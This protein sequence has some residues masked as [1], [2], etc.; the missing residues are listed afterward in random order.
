MMSRS[1]KKRTN[2]GDSSATPASNGAATENT[3]DNSSLSGRALIARFREE[4]A[5]RRRHSIAAPKVTS[6]SISPDTETPAQVKAADQAPIRKKSTKAKS[7]PADKSD[8]AE[9]PASTRTKPASKSRRRSP[10]Q[11]AGSDG[12]NGSSKARKSR[13]RKQ[14]ASDGP[15]SN[16][17][18]SV[19]IK[20]QEGVSQFRKMLDEASQDRGQTATLNSGGGNDNGAGMGDQWSQETNSPPDETSDTSPVPLETICDDAPIDDV[21][22]TAEAQAMETGLPDDSNTDRD[23]QDRSNTDDNILLD[24]TTSSEPGD[25]DEAASSEDDALDNHADDLEPHEADVQALS[26]E[27]DDDAHSLT[28]HDE[29]GASEEAASI[30]QSD[31]LQGVIDP[32]DSALASDAAGL[33][34]PMDAEALADDHENERAAVNQALQSDLACVSEIGI[35]MRKKLCQLGIETLVDLANADAGELR[36]GLGGLNTL[37]N[38]DAWIARARQEIEKRG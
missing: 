29:Q 19:W 25:P 27:S 16:I 28:E 2:T 30:E 34:Q 26:C 38:V 6:D 5:L 22:A 32:D 24:Y 36:S 7:E 31:D 12:N 8:L 35:G 15:D 33:D 17:D 1:I 14:Q 3:N 18:T 9:K 13:S 37:A 4:R 23:T 11:S 10:S 20:N 21:K